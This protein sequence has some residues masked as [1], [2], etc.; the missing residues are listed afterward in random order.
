MTERIFEDRTAVVT[1]GGRGIGRAICQ[2]LAERGARVAVNFEH[3]Q[4]AADETISMIAGQ[5]ERAMAVQADVSESAAVDR[6]MRAVRE[7]LGPIDFLINNAGIATTTSHHALKYE[8]WKRRFDINVDGPFLTTWAVKDEMIERQFGRIVNVSS[9]AGIKI[10]PDMIHYA[11]TKAAL[12]SFTRHCAQAFAPFNVRV[13]CVAPGL[14]DTDI[15]RN[16]NLELVDHLIAVTPMKRMAEPAEIASVV[17]FLLSD[18]SSFV[19]GQTVPACG[20]RC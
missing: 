15:T 16:G 20:G 11:T 3:N 1:G 7:Q 10:K 8:D 19:T 4:Q 2:M 14:T 5:A 13:N 12:I 6:M 18:D 9:L 17:K